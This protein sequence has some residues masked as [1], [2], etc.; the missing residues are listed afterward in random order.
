M[1]EEFTHPSETNP[2]LYVFIEA[3]IALLDAEIP[4][5]ARNSVILDDDGEVVRQKVLSEYLTLAP[6]MSLD[7]EAFVGLLNESLAPRN[8]P[9]SMDDLK[10]W[11]Q[12]LT[13]LG[14][15]HDAGGWMTIAQWREKLASPEYATEEE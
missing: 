4:A 9:V 12:F 11:D 6:C 2:G 13:P 8:L 14:L 1:Y 5:E 3:P 7:G 10:F 15:G